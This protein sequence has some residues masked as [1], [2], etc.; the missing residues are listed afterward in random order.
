MTDA[1]TR[2]LV[3]IADA[4]I[5]RPELFGDEQVFKELWRAA[6]AVREESTDVLRPSR[7]TPDGQYIPSA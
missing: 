4:L 2:L 5:D 1:Q 7:F 3:L 6:Q